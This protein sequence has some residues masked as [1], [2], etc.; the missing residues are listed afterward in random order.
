MSAR[1]LFSVGSAVRFLRKPQFDVKAIIAEIPQYLG[2]IKNR[3]LTVGDELQKQLQELPNYQTELRDC[4][5]QIAKIQADRKS[6]ENKLKQ[7]KSRISEL[8]RDLQD[9][10]LQYQ[11]ISEKRRLAD[12]YITEICLSLPNLTHDTVPT[13]GPQIVQWINPKDEYVPNAERDHHAIMARKQLVDFQTASNITGTS[14]YYLINEGAQLE[15]ALVS[16]ATKKARDRGFRM[17]L[18]PSI[19]KNEVIDACGFRPRDMNN[20]QQIYHL[21]NSNL[22]LTATAEITLAG[23]GINKVMSG[24]EPHKL[25]G[26]SRS[27]RAEAGARGRDTKG[28]YRVHE[29]T[30]V[31]LFCWCKPDQSNQLL[32]ELKNF[33]IDIITELGLSGKVLNMPANDLGAPAYKK[34]DIEVWMPGRGSFGEVTSTSNCTDFQSRRMNTKFRNEKSGKLEYIH[35]LNGTAMAV[36]RVI[37]ALVENFYNP[38]T[39]KIYVPKVLQAYMD[40]REYI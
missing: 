10:K 26:V 4:D 27:Y 14:W 38:E 16:Y 3:E 9:L 40:G 19:A 20:E 15:H 32:E 11:T 34:Y 37:L 35:T 33:Q 7:D 28:L 21:Q 8:K 17:C 2:S 12:E 29:F 5:Y 13:T 36:P 22:G 39:G 23:M 25:V 30:K 31:E 24:I 18:P 1:R 6:I